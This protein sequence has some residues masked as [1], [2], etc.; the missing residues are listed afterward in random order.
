MKWIKFDLNLNYAHK[1]T[2]ESWHWLVFAVYPNYKWL[3]QECT[4][5][6]I[7]HKHAFKSNQN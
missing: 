6:E 1:N 5:S 4:I 7:D 2:I 3:H